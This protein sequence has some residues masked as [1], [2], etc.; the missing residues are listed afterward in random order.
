MNLESFAFIFNLN[1]L[2][3]TY[4][5]HHPKRHAN[6][7]SGPAERSGPRHIT[8]L[9]HQPKVS[10]GPNFSFAGLLY[11]LDFSEEETTPLHFILHF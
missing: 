4:G 2:F 11:L 8:G 1:A 10:K 5:T 9:T 7:G 3:I 6:R